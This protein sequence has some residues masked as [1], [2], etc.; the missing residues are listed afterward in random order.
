MNSTLYFLN[1][2]LGWNAPTLYFCFYKFGFFFSSQSQS[3]K[4]LLT[5]LMFKCVYMCW[6]IYWL[7]MSQMKILNRSQAPW[8][9]R[10]AIL[11]YALVAGVQQFGEGAVAPSCSIISA[12]SLSAA[13]S[14]STPA[15]T[16]WMFSIGE[17]SSCQQQQKT[18]INTQTNSC[19]VKLVL[20]HRQL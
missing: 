19:T 1:I 14:Q 12:P 9:K 4:L 10:C 15:A 8:V 5:S 13:S 7:E 3:A 11:T 20:K 17:Y 18:H 16:R 2:Y 6:N